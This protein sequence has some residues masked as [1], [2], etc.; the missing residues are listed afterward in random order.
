MAQFYSDQINFQRGNPAL[1]GLAGSPNFIRNVEA[2]GGLQIWRFSYTVPASGGPVVSDVL[3]LAYLEP[4]ARMYGVFIVNTA[5]W[6]ASTTLS[7]GRVDPN[8]SANNSANRWVNG[9]AMSAAVLPI[10]QMLLAGEQVGV[11]NKGDLT[12]GNVPPAFGA[13]RITVQAT[14][15]GAAPTAG[16][17]LSGWLEYVEGN[18]A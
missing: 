15:G 10:N 17:V 6:G 9:L 16:S 13:S 2:G 18:Q 5:T 11:D 7:I 8:N 4:T 14:F 1:G 3:D 12:T